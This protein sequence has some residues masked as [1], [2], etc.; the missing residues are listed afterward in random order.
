[1]QTIRFSAALAASLA[2]LVGISSIAYGQVGGNPGAGGPGLGAPPVSGQAQGGNYGQPQIGLPANA[3]PS[4]AAMPSGHG[5]NGMGVID[6]KFIFSKYD[7]FD[8]QMQAIRARVEAAEAEVRKE[9]EAIKQ[10]GEKARTYDPSSPQFKQMEQDIMR[11]QSEM[12]IRV[13]TQKR[14]F[15]E[16]ESRIYYNTAKEIDDA[17]RII[18]SRFGLNI[19]FR[20]TPDEPNPNN[21]A[22]IAAVLGKSIFYYNGQMDITPYVL[23]ELKRPGGVAGGNVNP[24]M[25]QRP[26]PQMK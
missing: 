18:A 13:G 6:L 3:P 25:S 24:G 8:Q 16:D 4:G 15:G 23:Q 19:V 7:K 10:M 17:V 2:L 1:V 14:Q 26:V 20:V 21:R 5:V 11:R 22:E 9:Q 12:Q